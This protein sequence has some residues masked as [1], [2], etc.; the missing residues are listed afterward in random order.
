MIVKPLK[1]DRIRPN[2]L[3]IIEVVDKF[4]PSVQDG[5]VV[6]VTSKLVS[7]CE[8]RLVPLESTTIDDLIKSEAD[9]YLDA[10]ESERK[11]TIAKNILIPR[12]GID[13]SDF[14]QSYILW[15]SDPQK[16][17]NELRDFIK[18][19]Y[20]LSK[21]GIVITDSTTA[22]LMRGVRGIPL[23]HCGFSATKKNRS[24]VLAS[25]VQGLAAA[26]VVVM[27]EGNEQTPLA[28]IS[29][30]PFVDF[31]DHVPTPE[32]IKLLKLNLDDDIYSALL[33]SISWRTGEH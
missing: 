3:S 28:V 6:A 4:L 18:K 29:D 23:S 10:Q 25:I 2:T 15:P 11:L 19:K 16:T 12:A 22:P 13:V 31:V 5:S 26:A 1:T 24:D 20:K 21:L 14:S 30:V 8:N 17:A 9:Y 33:T 7:I 32:E 27:G